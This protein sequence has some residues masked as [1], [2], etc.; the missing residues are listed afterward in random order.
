MSLHGKITFVIGAS[1]SGKSRFAE[2]LVE[3]LSGRKVVYVA[4]CRT[5]GLSQDAEMMR[6][7]E[8][9]RR[10]RPGEWFTYENQMDLELIASE[11]AGK[12]ILLDCLTLW[13]SDAM[14]GESGEQ[15]AILSKLKAGADAMR[16]A[17]VHLV[18]VSNEVGAGIVPLGEG[19]REYR[20]LVGKGNQLISSASEDVYWVIAGIPVQIKKDGK[21][22]GLNTAES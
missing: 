5:E 8:N 4:T 17:N 19:I 14:T 18:V 7:I 15:D 13:L 21:L 10:Q 1:G 20:D 22:C 11:C 12:V 6:R 3:G 2:Q 16:S 9:H